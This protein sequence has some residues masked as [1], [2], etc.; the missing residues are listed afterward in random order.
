MRHGIWAFRNGPF[1]GKLKNTILKNSFRAVTTGLVVLLCSQSGCGI[2]SMTGAATA[3]KTITVDSFFNNTDLAPANIAQDFTNR[4][5]DYYQQNSSLR[6]TQENGEL[7]LEGTVSEY[8]LSPIAPQGSVPGATAAT[9]TNIAALTRLTIA[10]KVSYV[11][12][13]EPK[14]SFKDKTFSFY[15]DFDNNLV[16]T[17]SLQEELQKKIFDQILIDIFNATVANW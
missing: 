5:K 11:D 2:Y 17:T 10:V 1:T 8:R 3:A 4:I 14:N 13:T 6:V 7:Q 15:S 12:S 16:L 9:A